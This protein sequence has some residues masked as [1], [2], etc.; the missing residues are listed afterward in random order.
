MRILLFI[1]SASVALSQPFRTVSTDNGGTVVKPD[2]FWIINSN[3]VNS[4]VA[5]PASALTNNETRQ[6][7]F[8]NGLTVT[9]LT[10][11]TVSFPAISVGGSPSSYAYIAADNLL[12][13]STSGSFLTSLNADNISSGTLA[14]GRLPTT[15]PIGN[16]SASLTAPTVVLTNVIYTNQT[17]D[18]GATAT[19][20][21]T[22]VIVNIANLKSNDIITV[23][24]PA[25]AQTNCGIFTGWI[26][27]SVAMARFLNWKATTV[28]P[29][30][31]IFNI[32]VDQFR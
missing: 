28:D 1:L 13:K 10:A 19:L 3:G 2:N 7:V 16:I 4:V 20:T 32:R 17:I 30:S 21:A 8:Q 6:V 12:G 31:G 23:C 22:D 5:S 14:A 15:I 25:S 24:A 18:F 11:V 29:A 26:S 9:G 27:N